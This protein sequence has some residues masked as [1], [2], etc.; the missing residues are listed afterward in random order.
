M[1]VPPL[2]CF[3]ASLLKKE[4]AYDKKKVF[5]QRAL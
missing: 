5:K 4:E 3:A 2:F 1:K